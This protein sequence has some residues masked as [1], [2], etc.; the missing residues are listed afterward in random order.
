MSL[1]SCL[2]YQQLTGISTS[3]ALTV[4]TRADKALISCDQAAG[5]NVR[6]RDDGTAPTASI[7]MELVAGASMMYVGDLGAL[8]VIQVSSGAILNV[9]YYA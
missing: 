3:T 6:W 1:L 4:P 7:G 5:V 9:S 8:R 2:G